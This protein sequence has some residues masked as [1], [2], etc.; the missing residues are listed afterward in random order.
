LLEPLWHTPFEGRSTRRRD[1]LPLSLGDVSLKYLLCAPA[2]KH[3]KS[4]DPVKSPIE[5]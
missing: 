5:A 2:L 1:S 3:R 4:I